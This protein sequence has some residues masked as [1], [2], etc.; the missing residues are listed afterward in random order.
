MANTIS[1]MEAFNNGTGN[2]IVTVILC[3]TLVYELFGP[4]FTKLAL[5]KTGEIPNELGVY[6]YE[7]NN[8]Y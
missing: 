7:E 1:K 4:L 6:P 3:A 5:Q 8:K 2:I